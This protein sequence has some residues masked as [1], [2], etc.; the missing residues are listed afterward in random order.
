MTYHIFFSDL[1][2]ENQEKMIQTVTQEL[3]GTEDEG[4]DIE[5]IALIKINKQFP[6]T[7]VI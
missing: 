1:T 7:I 2:K 5:R 4:E 6:I 3:K